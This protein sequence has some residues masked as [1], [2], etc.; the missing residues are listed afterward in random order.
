MFSA[1]AFKSSDRELK[2]VISQNRN[3]AIDRGVGELS[4]F[5]KHPKGGTT[6]KKLVGNADFN[7]RNLLWIVIVII[8]F[9][10]K[11]GSTCNDNNQPKID[12]SQRI[13]EIMEKREAI[14]DFDEIRND[15][16]KSQRLV[17]GIYNEKSVDFNESNLHFDFRDGSTIETD[18]PVLI[19]NKSKKPLVFVFQSSSGVIY[20]CIK[21]N[22]IRMT[23]DYISKFFI[24]SGKK[25]IEYYKTDY[26]KDNNKGFKFNNFDEN[27][28]KNLKTI[29][30]FSNYKK[31]KNTVEII[32]TKNDVEINAK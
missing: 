24:Y 3:Y 21:P 17:E 22:S 15:V 9:V 23:K 30:D 8:I 10:G 7:A 28:I 6:S 4:N 13:I 31:L 16:A 32:I 1:G 2:S 25:P 26:L 18:F 12:M 11:I 27:D 14:F 20:Y 19:N 5:K 29:H